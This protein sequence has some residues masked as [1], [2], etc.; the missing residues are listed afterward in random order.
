MNIKNP[1]RLKKPGGLFVT[2]TLKNYPLSSFN[3]LV[4]AGTT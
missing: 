2:I 1:P 4:S 3:F